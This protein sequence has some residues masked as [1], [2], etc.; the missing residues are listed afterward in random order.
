M[1]STLI[2]TAV[3][4]SVLTALV[5]SAVAYFA[6]PKLSTVEA[7]GQGVTLQPPAAASN[8]ATPQPAVSTQRKPSPALVRRTNYV[9]PSYSDQDNN[10]VATRDAAGEPVVNHDRSTGKS[11]AIVAGSAGAGAA[12]GALAGGGKGAAIG[13]ISGGAAGFIYDRMTA[14]K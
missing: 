10:T 6:A 1:K 14:H 13:A 5:V 12:I 8:G 4:A 2:R 11:V 3:L 9:P 7:Q